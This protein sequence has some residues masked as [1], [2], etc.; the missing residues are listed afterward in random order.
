MDLADKALGDAGLIHDNNMTAA[1]PAEGATNMT[2][3][4]GAPIRRPG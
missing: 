4:G 1:E 3:K 2:T